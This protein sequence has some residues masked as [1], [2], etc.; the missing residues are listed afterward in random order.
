VQPRKRNRVIA[1]T[2]EPP[3]TSSVGASWAIRTKSSVPSSRHS[4]NIATSTPKSPIRFMMKAFLP[5]SA[6][7][8]S[9]NQNPIS[10]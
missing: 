3:A 2:T 10:R 7:A 5:A 1:V 8:F 6:L 9:L 4:R